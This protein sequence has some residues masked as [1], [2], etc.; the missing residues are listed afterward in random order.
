MTDT[1]ES[2]EEDEEDEEEDGDGRAAA[3]S[4]SLAPSESALESE[5]EAA[6]TF[7]GQAEPG[8]VA[9]SEGDDGAEAAAV[10]KDT[11]LC[12]THSKNMGPGHPG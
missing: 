10:P 11:V 8:G 5:S 9:Q 4:S 12:L 3:T 6:G 2:E 7:W 1:S